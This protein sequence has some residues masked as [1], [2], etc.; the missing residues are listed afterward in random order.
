MRKGLF[1][2]LT[3][4]CLAAF[5]GCAGGKDKSDEQPGEATNAVTAGVSD[6][7]FELEDYEP[8]N[9]S[10][11]MPREMMRT[12]KGFYHLNFKDNG[13]HYYD[14][15][16]GKEMYLCNKPECRH[17]GNPFCVATNQTYEILGCSLYNDKI[18]SY[19]QEETD[20]QYAFK[21]L[22][23]ALDGSSADELATVLTIEKTGERVA[24]AGCD[25]HI[26]RNKVLVT[27]GG[28]S[29]GEDTWHYCAAVVDLD[30]KKVTFL[31]EEPFS[32][33]NEDLSDISAYGD[34]FYY[35][36]KEGKKRLL[37]RYHIG[38]G[39]T[40]TCKLLTNFSGDYAVLDEDCVVYSRKSGLCTYR[41][42]TGENEEKT[43]LIGIQKMYEGRNLVGETEA[44][45]VAQDVL[46][47]GTYLY[48]PQKARQLGFKEETG[49]ITTWTE[50]ANI[51]VFDK[52]LGEIAVVDLMAQFPKEGFEEM[53]WH[54]DSYTTGLR[55]LGEDIYWCLV[56][57]DEN[58]MNPEMTTYV[59]HCN[60]SDFLAGEPKFEFVYKYSEN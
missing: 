33:D 56:P 59:F 22:T 28:S 53:T 30:T 5:M 39:T 49:E 51:H 32:K 34:Y 7:K 60:R 9:R 31:N 47:D 14:M 55:Y 4:L 19:V 11:F 40:E 35:C 45:Y 54:I 8:G 2:A 46:T 20:T 43:R 42:S 58:N 52:N 18:L 36:Q 12:E 57:L 29:V 3:I 26:H 6:V 10:D 48:I 15:S 1:A 16:T 41:F 21:L 44:E 23:V 17:D 38:N 27:M 13:L 50:S 37:R 25:V 24:F